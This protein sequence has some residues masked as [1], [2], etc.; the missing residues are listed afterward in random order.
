MNQIGIMPRFIDSLASRSTC[1]ITAV[2]S[3][4]SYGHG[5]AHKRAW[6]EG[7][8]DTLLTLIVPTFPLNYFSLLRFIR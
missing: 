2:I 3:D 8:K 1:L 5:S 6:L 7:S 4:L